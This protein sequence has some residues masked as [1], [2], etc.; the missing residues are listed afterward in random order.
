MAGAWQRCQ[1]GRRSRP[2]SWRGGPRSASVSPLYASCQAERQPPT[3]SCGGR[4]R[5]PRRD[6]NARPFGPQ[7]N[8]LSKLSY[9]GPPACANGMAHASSAARHS[10]AA[11]L[12][13]RGQAGGEGGIRTLGRGLT[14]LQA[15]SRRPRSTTPAPPRV[16]HLGG[17]RGIRTPGGSPHSC[18]Q[19]SRLRPLGHPSGF[20]G[21]L[22]SADILP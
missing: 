10:W 14:P 6:S 5:R 19:D 16:G 2:S 7:P 21:P 4:F 9:E 18:F 12:P 15:L 11:L 17:G 22:P 8:A 3:T 1:P 13:A 20:R